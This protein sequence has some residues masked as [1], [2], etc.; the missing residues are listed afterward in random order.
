[1]KMV[2]VVDGPLRDL[3][4]QNKYFLHDEALWMRGDVISDEVRCVQPSP[5]TYVLRR[6]V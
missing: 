5:A 6:Y 2:M 4:E 3:C 1:M